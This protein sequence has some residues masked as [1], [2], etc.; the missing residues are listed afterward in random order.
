MFD[1][2]TV[3]ERFLRHVGEGLARLLEFDP[4][5]RAALAALEER[6]IAIEV[7]GVERTF[8][9]LVGAR[10]L[11]L[12]LEHVGEVHVRARGTPSSFLTLLSHRL[13]Q[14]PVPA[15]TIEILGD[16]RTAQE[17]QDIFSRLDID[18]EEMLSRLFGDIAAHKSANAARALWS[19]LR[20]TQVSMEM[21][22]SEY[23][24]YETEILPDRDQVERYHR[25]IDALR[26]HA[27][28]L[29]ERLRRLNAMLQ[30]HPRQTN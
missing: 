24:Q 17:L 8:Y 3:A 10:G 23:A 1:L 30:P 4:A 9:L 7:A 15:G 19:W 25:E 20:S 28:R 29:A 22:I 21:N 12:R 5:T 2:R 26:A 6:V 11:L 13:R 27:D 14:Q 18:W 16:L